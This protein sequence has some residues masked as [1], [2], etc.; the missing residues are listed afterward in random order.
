MIDSAKAIG[1]GRYYD[2][3]VWDFFTKKTPVEKMMPLGVVLTIPATGSEA[4]NTTV[5]TNSENG[6]MKR[7]L[8]HECL[9]PDFALMNPELTYTLPAYQTAAGG[10]DILSH[11]MERYF[12]NEEDCELT[13]RQCE[14]L[15]KTVIKQLPVVMEKP[16]DYAARAEVMWA[17]TMA[18]NGV[19]GVGRVEDW[20]SHMLGHELSAYYDMTHG[21][22]LSIIIPHWMEYVYQNNIARFVKYAVDVWGIENDVFHPEE[23]A[24]RG[25]QKTKEF[26]KS[27]GLPV[28]FADAGIDG[29]KIEE[30]AEN[31]T[32]FG[33]V[34]HFIKLNKEDCVQIYQASLER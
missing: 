20:G 30:M 18:H 14:A 29:E 34:G 9:R 8:S 27:L 7:A 10:V 28:S 3:D 33:S 11:I 1:I 25:I 15:M 16:E 4:S 24:V 22:T 21:A 32:K 6:H 19:L 13:D 12:T 31:C 2:G 5:V 17:G 23:T 26:F